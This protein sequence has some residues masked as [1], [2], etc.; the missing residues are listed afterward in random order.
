MCACMFLCICACL[1]ICLH[2]RPHVCQL[3]SIRAC[4]HQ[5]SWCLGIKIPQGQQGY[6]V[7]KPWCSA[8]HNPG[9]VCMSLINTTLSLPSCFPPEL[10][11]GFPKWSFWKLPLDFRFYLKFANSDEWI[12]ECLQLWVE[13]YTCACVDCTCFHTCA[14]CFD[15]LFCVRVWPWW[16]L[17]STNQQ[18]D[19]WLCPSPTLRTH[20]QREE[21]TYSV[22]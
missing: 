11:L 10:S 1:F 9:H 14:A 8:E 6:K 19:A 13:V 22:L 15:V 21:T 2:T 3:V 4:M 5:V 18:V 12:P 16:S 7:M 17:Q 20:R